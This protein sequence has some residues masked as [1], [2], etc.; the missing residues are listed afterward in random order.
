MSLDLETI[1]YFLYMEEQDKEQTD[2][3]IEDQ[4]NE[5]NKEV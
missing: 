2:D 5:D 1:G 3:N 4:E